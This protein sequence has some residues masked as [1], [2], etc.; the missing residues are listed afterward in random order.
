MPTGTGDSGQKAY[1]QR[2][3]KP[4]RKDAAASTA[5]VSAF[6]GRF[7]VYFPSEDTVARS[8]G[9]KNVGPLAAAHPKGVT[10]ADAR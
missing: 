4:K 2:T 9:G 6:S 8:R 7:R 3:Q 5:P 10:T 1:D